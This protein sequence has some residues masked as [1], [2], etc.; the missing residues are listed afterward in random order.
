MGAVR[1]IDL[2]DIDIDQLVIHLRHCPETK[3]APGT[4][5]K[6]GIDGERIINISVSLRDLLA[7]Y[8][9]RN[10]HDKKRPI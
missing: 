10:R 4:P 3:D 6:N 7:D 1:A 5:L 8:I 2:P 9:D